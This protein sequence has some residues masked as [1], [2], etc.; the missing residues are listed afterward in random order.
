MY[1]LNPLPLAIINSFLDV[2]S[3]VS[4]NKLTYSSN[5]LNFHEEFKIYSSFLFFMFDSKF[6][7]N[8]LF[9]AA[10]SMALL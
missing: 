9:A 5:S 8:P 1:K 7:I 3:L 4:K 2:V 10:A 6:I